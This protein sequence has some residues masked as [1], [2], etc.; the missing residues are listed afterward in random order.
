MRDCTTLLKIQ[1][2][3]IC[4]IL[5]TQYFCKSIKK[6]IKSN[7]QHSFFIT[8][9]DDCATALQGWECTTRKS[10]LLPFVLVTP[11]HPLFQIW[12]V[13][14]STGSQLCG[15][16]SAENSQQ[17]VPHC[18]PCQLPSYPGCCLLLPGRAI[19]LYQL[20]T[21]P[22]F[23][24]LTQPQAG[25]GDTYTWIPRSELDAG[26]WPFSLWWETR[27]KSLGHRDCGCS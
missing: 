2:F 6:A 1:L 8:H 23:Q 24:L 3:C 19:Q 20:R 16:T 12:A 22:S 21:V 27:W 5:F 18:G 13:I 9:A 4:C 7:W 14:K 25:Q 15:P 10:P 11:Q 26:C 17:H